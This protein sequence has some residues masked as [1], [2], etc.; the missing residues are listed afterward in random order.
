MNTLETIVT[1]VKLQ[2][3]SIEV[4]KAVQLELVRIGLLDK[5]D[6]IAGAKTIGAFHQFKQLASLGDYD[7]LGQTTAKRLLEF[8]VKRG[9]TPESVLKIA[10]SYLGYKESPPGSNRTKFGEWYGMDGQPWCAQFVSYCFYIAGLP[11]P[12]TT[13]KG[14]AYCPYGVNWFK[15]LKRFYTTPAVGDVVFF[16]WG[17]DGVSDHVGIVEAVNLDGTVTTIEGNTSAS[18]NSNGGEVQRRK[19]SLSQIQGFGRPSYK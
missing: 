7:T 6:G 14:F 11:L 4:V 5:V 3:A 10:T 9:I 17:K 1:P 18:N 8:Q 2:D 12:A 16:D 19:R 15:Q 13:S